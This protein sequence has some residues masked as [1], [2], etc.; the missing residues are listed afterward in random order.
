M[1]ELAGQCGRECWLPL[2]GA[3]ENGEEIVRFQI[4]Q[5]VSLGSR[6]DR[7]EQRSVIFSCSQDDH[8]HFGRLGG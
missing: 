8:F 5:Q 7:F 1:K 2:T 6:F 4:L 3:I